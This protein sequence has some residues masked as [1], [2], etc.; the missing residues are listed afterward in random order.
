MCEKKQIKSRPYNP[1]LYKKRKKW[2]DSRKLSKEEI[3]SREIISRKWDL[4]I[5]VIEDLI[6]R[7]TV[8]E[9]IEWEFEWNVF[10]PGKRL[11]TKFALVMAIIFAIA[12]SLTTGYTLP[13]PVMTFIS[14]DNMIWDTK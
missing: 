6:E 10:T 8:T 5:E 2:I 1:R 3:A 11:S 14:N 7:F 13:E 4:R 9:I 12:M